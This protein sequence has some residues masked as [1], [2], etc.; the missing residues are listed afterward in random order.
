M[1]K[2]N[3]HINTMECS[4]ATKRNEVLTH[5]QHDGLQNITL[6]EET[7]YKGPYIV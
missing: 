1:D 3:V 4:L 6:S 7:S 2:Q 5:L